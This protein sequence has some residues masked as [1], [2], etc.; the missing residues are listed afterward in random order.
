MAGGLAS[1][2]LV[3]NRNYLAIRVVSA[4]RAF[5]L[6]CKEAAEVVTVEDNLFSTYD[7]TDWIELSRMRDAWPVGDGEWVR[8]VS[9]DIRVP[10]IVRLFSYDR[11][12]QRHVRLSRRNIYA[13]DATR[14]QY[15][16]RKFHTSELSIDHV[17]PRSQGGHT[18][19]ANVV[20]CCMG[21]NV[22]KGGRTPRQAGMRLKHKPVRPARS[23]AITLRLMSSKYESWKHFLDTVYWN[24]ELRD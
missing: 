13:R 16:G 19:W 5:M 1:S 4:R 6:L 23:P 24:V 7:F 2:V 21:C 22:K 10:R 3:L 14:C 18:T 20:C 11:V 12:P 8:T 9:F 15:C 17:V